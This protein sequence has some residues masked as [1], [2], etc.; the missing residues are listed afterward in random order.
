MK[1]KD[2]AKSAVDDKERNDLLKINSK[3]QEACQNINSNLDL[4]KLR[5]ADIDSRINEVDEHIVEVAN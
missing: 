2:T 1:I 3:I 4:T 5:I